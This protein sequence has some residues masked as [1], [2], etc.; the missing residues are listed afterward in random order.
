M[1]SLAPPSAPQAIPFENLSL[2]LE[3]AAQQHGVSTELLPIYRKMV[4]GGRGGYCL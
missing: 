3:Q 1:H 4:Q 2:R